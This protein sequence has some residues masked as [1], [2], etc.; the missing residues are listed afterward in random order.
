MANRAAPP[1][2][3][4]GGWSRRG[5]GLCDTHLLEKG[6]HLGVPRL[7]AVPGVDHLAVAV[8]DVAHRHGGAPFSLVLLK[9]DLHGGIRGIDDVRK[10]YAVVAQ[11]FQGNLLVVGTVEAQNDQP[12]VLVLHVELLEMTHLLAAGRSAGPP[13]VEP[14]DLAAEVGELDLRFAVGRGQ[15]EVRRLGARL[16]AGPSR[17][18]ASSTPSSPRAASRRTSCRGS[19]R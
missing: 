9:T 18:T 8:D 4:A 5:R 10:G 6:L 16:Q 19:R 1:I 13:D 2:D 11:H 3:K 15:F 17:S 14:D 12:L 7:V